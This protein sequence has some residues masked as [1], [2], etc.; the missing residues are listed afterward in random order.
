MIRPWDDPIK[1]TGH[2]QI[3]RGSLAP[4]GAVGK[5]TGKEGLAFSGTAK[6][7]D[8]EEAIRVAAEVLGADWRSQRFAILHPNSAGPYKRW[9]KDGWERLVAH[10]REHGAKLGIARDD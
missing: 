10:L 8:G 6:V 5:V 4:E 7:F 3:L 1:D 9:H 2:I